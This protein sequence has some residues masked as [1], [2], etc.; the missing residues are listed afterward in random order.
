M[1][2]TKT[3]PTPQP[4]P[5]P[6]PSSSTHLKGGTVVGQPTVLPLTAVQPNG[7]NPNVMTDHTFASLKHGLQNEGWLANQ[8]LL[9]WA[10]DDQGEE[11]M[12]I[13]DGEH[14]WRAASQ[15]GFK[16]GPMVLLNGVSEA[17]AKTLTVAMNQKRGEFDAAGLEAL[18]KSIEH[19]S[20]DLALATGIDEDELAKL[21][22]VTEESMDLDAPAGADGSIPRVEPAAQPG[23]PP[24]APDAP[25]GPSGAA[26]ASTVRMVQLFLNSDNVG[27]FNADI[28]KIAAIYGTK[29]VTD[30]VK[31]CVSRAARAASSPSST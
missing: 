27:E 10:T 13:I 21:L 22:A 6:P 19:D 26:P 31:E 5:T 16:E 9:V 2:K 11:K 7:W 25:G 4:A 20:G 3:A 18:L 14:R 29:T 28:G 15:L 30:T 24:L 23:A 1:A 12:L 8:S 17:R